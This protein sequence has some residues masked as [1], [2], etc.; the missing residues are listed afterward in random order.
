M[1]DICDQSDLT[2]EH[3]TAAAL[4]MVA[5]PPN[6]PYLGT[7]CT[8]GCGCEVEQRRAQLGYTTCIECA[9]DVVERNKHYAANGGHGAY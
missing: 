7:I 1:P 6:A 9:N 3:N 8:E 2:I 4:S 5:K